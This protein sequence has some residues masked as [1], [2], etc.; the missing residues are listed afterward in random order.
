MNKPNGYDEAK[1]FDFERERLILGGHRCIIMKVIEKKSSTG[2]EQLE[3]HLDTAPDDAQPI[4]FSNQFMANGSGTWPCR[5]WI[6]GYETEGSYGQRQLKAFHTA[7]ED[8]NASF[9]IPWGP[10][11]ADS[12]KGKRVGVVFGEEEN[13]WNGRISTLTKP[14]YF[15]SVLEVESANVPQKK[16]IKPETPEK[17]NVTAEGFMQVQ[18]DLEDEGLPF[19]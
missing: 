5:V 10:T 13:E 4:F 19:N 3:I 6:T 15:R 1:A 7:V 9:F 12:L 16:T 2:K 17:P 18:D 8:S 11:Y 14:R